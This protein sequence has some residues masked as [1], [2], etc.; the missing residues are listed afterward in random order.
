M[1]IAPARSQPLSGHQAYPPGQD[2]IRALTVRE[3][4]FQ[5]CPSAIAAML[6]HAALRHLGGV[7][8]TLVARGWRATVPVAPLPHRRLFDLVTGPL[9]TALRCQ[10]DPGRRAGERVEPVLP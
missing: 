2:N 1:R 4:N 6:M 5:A 3:T 10:L 9:L 8:V 7:P